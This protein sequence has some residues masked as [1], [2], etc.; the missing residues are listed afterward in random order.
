MPAVKRRLFNVLAAVSLVLCVAIVAMWIRSYRVHDA[1]EIRHSTIRATF[2]DNREACIATIAGSFYPRWQHMYG[3]PGWQRGYSHD[4]S[5]VWGFQ[6]SWLT[7]SILPE[8]RSWMAR[9]GYGRVVWSKFGFTYISRRD[10]IHAGGKSG[11][12]TRR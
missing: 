3:G 4:D 11:G 10:R 9:F 1:V 6:T 5:T 12:Q 2:L 7:P 8:P